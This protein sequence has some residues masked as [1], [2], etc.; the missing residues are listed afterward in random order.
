MQMQYLITIIPAANSWLRWQDSNLRPIAYIC[1][2]ITKRDGLYHRHIQL[3]ELRRKA[4]RSPEA[5]YSRGIVSEPAFTT[6]FAIRSFSEG[7]A[8]DYPVFWASSNS[9]CFRP[10]FRTGSCVVRS[11]ATALP[12]SYTGIFLSSSTAHCRS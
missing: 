4:L 10:G 3:L 9:P 11:Q 7:L 2:S 5:N 6:C 12:L 1:P 8:A